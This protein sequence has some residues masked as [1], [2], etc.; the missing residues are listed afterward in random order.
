MYQNKQAKLGTNR[1][2]RRVWLQAKWL[3]NAGFPRG[4]GYRIEYS[5][6]LVTISRCD[7]K[8][9][10][11]V[12]GAGDRP[13]IDINTKQLGDSLGDVDTVSVAAENGQITIRSN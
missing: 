5:R 8:P 4:A 9:T 13:I 3:I 2:N 10:R 12:A 1:G 11:R 7:S 6:K